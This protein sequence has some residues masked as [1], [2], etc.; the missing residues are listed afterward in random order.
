M[1]ERTNLIEKSEDEP[2]PG[3]IYMDCMA[4]GM[5]NGCFQITLGFCTLNLSKF[6]YDLL[7]P[8]TPILVLL[9]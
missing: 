9:Y 2:Y 4:F 5:G 6:A 1:D 3:N 7:T 8:L